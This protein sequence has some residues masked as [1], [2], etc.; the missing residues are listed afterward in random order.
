MK[1]V[2]KTGKV[3]STNISGKRGV[4]KLSVESIEIKVDHGIVED[5]HAGFDDVRQ[6]SML[7]IESI[8]KMRAKGLDVNPGDFAEN[9]TTEGIVLYELP[10]GTI[11]QAGDVELQVTQIGKEC[12]DRCVIYYQAGDC[13]MPREGI[14]V[15]SLNPGV[16]RPED[17]IKVYSEE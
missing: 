2:L 7:A 4:R 14:F 11:M 13:V 3:V 5:A 17:E 9:I 10:V 16:I 8:D 1:K 12:K 6:I 15:R